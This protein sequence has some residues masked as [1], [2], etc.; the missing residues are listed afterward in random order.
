M[1]LIGSLLMAEGFGK[2]DFGLTSADE[3]RA[4]HL[5]REALVVDMLFQGPVGY[6]FFT[7]EI[8]RKQRDE[9]ETHRDPSR[10]MM[11]S[12]R[13]PT[14]MALEGRAPEYEQVWR[15]SGIDAA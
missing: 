15:A 10:S 11:E 1:T 2:F 12:I 4:L 14:R 9:Y 13:M 7:E 3:E 6:R 8:E 5:H